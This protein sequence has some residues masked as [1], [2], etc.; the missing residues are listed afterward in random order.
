MGKNRNVW[1]WTALFLVIAATGPAGFLTGHTTLASKYQAE[2]EL[3]YKLNRS[4]LDGLGKINGRIYVTG[5]KSPDADTVGSSIG[6]AVLLK[7]LGYDVVVISS[8]P[9]KIMLDELKCYEGNIIQELRLNPRY[10]TKSKRKLLVQRILELIGEEFSSIKV[11]SA[12]IA[13]AE[14]AELIAER[15]KCKHIIL[16]YLLK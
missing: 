14:W 16:F 13:H 10:F 2:R 9:G 7:K 3:N 4:D 8:I 1:K 15:L 12:D 5:H 6:Y 11:D